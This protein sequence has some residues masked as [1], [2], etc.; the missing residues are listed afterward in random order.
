MNVCCP[1]HEF[2]SKLIDHGDVFWISHGLASYKCTLDAEYIEP[3]YIELFHISGSR[4]IPLEILGKRKYFTYQII[5]IPN[6]FA[7]LVVQYIR[8]QL[9]LSSEAEMF[10]DTKLAKLPF[11]CRKII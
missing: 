9:Y 11:Y 10:Y 4:N 8:D 1:C 6:Y 2:L 5:D 3:R 7:I